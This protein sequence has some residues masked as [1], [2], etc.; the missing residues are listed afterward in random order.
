M[1]S[2]SWLLPKIQAYVLTCRHSISHY[3][4]G[5][6]THDNAFTSGH[7]H[8]SPHNGSYGDHHDSISHYNGGTWTHDD[9]VTSGLH[10]GGPHNGSSGDHHD[11]HHNRNSL[12][13]HEWG[14]PS[15]W[16]LYCVCQYEHRNTVAADD[17]H[18]RLIRRGPCPH[19]W[20]HGSANFSQ[21]HSNYLSRWV[22]HNENRKFSWCRLCWHWQHAV[23]SWTLRWRYNEH[24]GVSNHLRLNC[25]HKLLFRRRSKKT[26]K[27]RV[28]GLCAGNPPVTGGFPSQRA[29]HTE[30]VFIWWRHHGWQKQRVFIMQTL[31]S[32]SDTEWVSW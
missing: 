20:R 11:D 13:T 28:T 19:R 10:H 18:M 16:L 22:L 3:N 17:I 23:S 30:N 2:R 29:S 21:L 14:G 5:T 26:S 1:L 4:G 25:L 24:D 12:H 7:H 8:G 15:R 32:P 6:W 27:L 9:A 31:S